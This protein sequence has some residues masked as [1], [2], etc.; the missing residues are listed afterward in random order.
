MVLEL[1]AIIS[2]LNM[3]ASALNKTAQA[4]QDLSQISGYLSALAEGQHDLQRLQ[5]T[6]TLSAA[7][8]VKAQL[9]KKEADD[10]LAQVRE[11]FIYSGNQRLWDDAMTAMAEARK[12]RAAEIRRL[13][14]ARKRRKKEL[15]QLAI[16]IAVSVGLIPIAI[17]LAIWLIFQI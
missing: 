5:N 13:E 8:A 7:D 6:K 15:T 11:A 10:A 12:A 4:T 9:A 3:A 1:G 2:G 17:M 14:L 16:V